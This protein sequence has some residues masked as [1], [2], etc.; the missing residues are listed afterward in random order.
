MNTKSMQLGAIALCA[1]VA[2]GLYFLPKNAPAGMAKKMALPN[3]DTTFSFEAFQTE[4]K[5]GLDSA[6]LSELS[7]W[8]TKTDTA[9]LRKI[10]DIWS[11]FR[12]A[13][14]S[15]FYIEKLA[16]VAPTTE[17]WFNAGYR[18]MVAFRTTEK[19][20]EKLYFTRKAITCFKTVLDKDST[21]LEAKANLGVC[22]VEGA[23]TLGTAPMQGVKLLLDVVGKDPKNITALVNLGYFSIQ[24]GQLD[25]AIER[26]NQI[27]EI[28]PDYLEA[29]IY[30]A[31][32]YQ[33]QGKKEEA[34]KTLEI[35]K[36]KNKDPELEAN[37]NQYIQD[38]KS[39]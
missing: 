27:I 2:L 4:A 17:N 34:I 19:N 5:N 10:S 6:S 1:V 32:A 21:N 38:L 35:L 25:K 37:I 11:S 20:G 29:Y 15:G 13:G 39:S 7:S 9:S 3:A 28:K 23:Q 36:S 24:S 31:D 18:Y 22:Y 12:N 26:F 30:L 33:R 14:L 8:E 16:L